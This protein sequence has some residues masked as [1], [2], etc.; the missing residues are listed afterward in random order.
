MGEERAA[1]R[2]FLETEPLLLISFAAGCC[3]SIGWS[4]RI[5]KDG[6]EKDPKIF[7][8]VDIFLS[9]RRGTKIDQRFKL[10]KKRVFEEL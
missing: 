9:S 2:G 10:R 3:R 6:D 1:W 4:H 5:F 7:V 8:T